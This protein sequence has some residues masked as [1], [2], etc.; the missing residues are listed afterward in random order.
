[1]AREDKSVVVRRS[2]RQ[3]KPSP[4]VKELESP[5]TRL[6]DEEQKEK[7]TLKRARSSETVG[8]QTGSKV[9]KLV[10]EDLSSGE[11]IKVEQV[12]ANDF[13]EERINKIGT[14]R[15]FTKLCDICDATFRS[16]F[17]LTAHMAEV[18]T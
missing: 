6:K 15:K 7:N 13:Q 11:G 1:M 14:A 4:K 5:P 3:Y 12:D 17:Q 9:A 10:N 16:G 2:S 18:C 8:K